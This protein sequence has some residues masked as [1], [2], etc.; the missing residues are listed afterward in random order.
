MSA[1]GTTIEMCRR[2]VRV[3]A[4]LAAM[5]ATCVGQPAPDGLWFDDL[6]EP[7]PV[8]R[9]DGKRLA[10]RI[11]AHLAARGQGKAQA[12]ALPESLAADA[13]PRI[14]LLS[15]SDGRTGA[16][17][18]LG[19]GQGMAAAVEAAVAR[20]VPL[21]PSDAPRLW[22]KLDIVTAVE[23]GVD[24]DPVTGRRLDR[25]LQGFAFDRRSQI[26]FLPEQVV[27]HHL[28]D[29][30]GRLWPQSI[31]RYLKP[32]SP[33]G[34]AF[35]DAFRRPQ[36]T[37]VLFRTQAFFSDG[38]ATVALFRGH[39]VRDDL[40]PLS[41]QALLEASRRAGDY[42][43]RAIDDQGRFD[44]LLAAPQGPSGDAADDYNILRHAGT[45]Y[46]LLELHEA[47]RQEPILAAAERGIAHLLKHVASAPGGDEA[48]RCIVEGGVAKLGGNALAVVAL[49]QHARVTGRR[50]HVETM[51][52]LGRWMVSLQDADGRFRMHSMTVPEGR[53]TGFQSQYY[54]GEAILALLR[55]NAVDPAPVWLDAAEKG[56]RWLITVRDAQVADNRLNHD[57]WLLYA[58]NELYR[59]RRDE[60]FLKHAQRLARVIVAAQIRDAEPP[61]WCGGYLNPPRS[62]PTATRTEGLCAAWR[63]ERDFGRPEQAR[64]LLGALCR[65]AEFV[66]RTQLGPESVLYA[67]DPQRWLGGFRGSLTDMT[68]RIDYVQHSLSAMLGLRQILAAESDNAARATT[69]GSP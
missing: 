50:D 53:D 31:V 26:V 1:F 52:R 17:V 37:G 25:S 28:A 18:V 60:L 57:H 36:L 39:V 16:Q 40:P 12:P 9:E 6:G 20:A 5:A 61:D 66:Q 11:H 55:L 13:A 45:V 69:P 41:S 32:S 59:I 68:V 34:S 63:L 35:L 22:L 29:D 42:L 58:L 30:K 3:T 19:T 65:G 56:A 67:D 51:R 43:V 49:A 46:S 23:A 38:A 47:D 14:V 7:A 44:Y 2:V 10:A 48:V 8:S 33:R 21:V 27:A 54:P 64:D 24:L 15:L 4:L 62:T